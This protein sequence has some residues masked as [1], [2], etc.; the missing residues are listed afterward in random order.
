MQ[1]VTPKWRWWQLVCP[2]VLELLY[3]KTSVRRTKWEWCV[4]PSV[5]RFIYRRSLFPALLNWFIFIYIFFIYDEIY[6]MG[7]FITIVLF[8][9]F[10]AGIYNILL[11]DLFINLA[12][13]LYCTQKLTAWKHLL[14]LCCGFIYIIIYF[15]LH[16]YF[17]KL[18]ACPLVLFSCKLHTPQLLDFIFS[19]IF[20]Q[21]QEWQ[22][23]QSASLPLCVVDSI[24]I[25][26]HGPPQTSP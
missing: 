15:C 8:A 16:N 23:S 4:Y 7:A 10:N 5:C 22:A 25:C 1:E 17:T 14:P 19:T 26:L 2:R 9:L 18:T 20:P 21:P 24:I 12:I 3:H 11:L 13:Y 6:S